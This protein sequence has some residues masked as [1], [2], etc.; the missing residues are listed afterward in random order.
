V[1]RTTLAKSIIGASLGAAAACVVAMVAG[2]P[3][4]ALF[5]P[6]HPAA[7][8]MIAALGAAV[9]LANEGRPRHSIL[10]GKLLGGAAC[11]LAAWPGAAG[12]RQFV[13]SV[14]FIGLAVA[15]RDVRSG[16]LS[17]AD[18]AAE[19]AAAICALAIGGY[20]V[21]FS[22]YY[23][24]DGQAMGFGTTCVLLLLSVAALALRTSGSVYGV[25]TSSAPSAIAMRVLLPLP[26]VFP[27]IF[28]VLNTWAI[29]HKVYAPLAGAWMFATANTVIYAALISVVAVWLHRAHE[30]TDQA[31]EDLRIL[32]AELE[33]RVRLRTE[34]LTR[35]NAELEQFAYI[36]SHDLQE[37]LRS[38]VTYA[39][40]LER[41]FESVLDADGKE[42]LGYIEDGGRRMSRLVQ[43]LLSYSRVLHEESERLD[44]DCASIIVDVLKDLRLE[45][46]EAGAQVD[47]GN[48]PRISGNRTQI[49]QVFHNLIGNALKYRTP[50]MPA[51]VHVGA[52]LLNDRWRFRVSDNGIGIAPEYHERVFGLFKRLHRDRYPGT[53]LGLAMCR[54]AIEAH[55]GRIWV[56]SSPGAGATFWFDLPAVEAKAQTA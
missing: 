15:L 40:L 49:Q 18:M 41:R 24:A 56:E 16:V 53:G 11:A 26:F 37:P 5:A 28:A 21:R 43:D 54:R 10:A 50:G 31:R 44:V 29:S 55:G 52:E 34:E 13:S 27:F 47:I 46:A 19:V 42:F 6:A 4:P 39:Q 7:A 35:S 38:V 33:D 51:L 36:A 48:L 20:A 45:I 1:N 14:F 30:Q 9:F 23:V 22:P 17:L 2:K 3:V 12:P 25:L 8:A 32:N